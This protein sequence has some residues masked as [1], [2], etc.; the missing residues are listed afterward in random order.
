MAIGDP[1][2]PCFTLSFR[3]N[4]ALVSTVRR[5]VADFYQTWLP[6]ELTSEVALATHELLENAVI[7]SCNGE[8]EV[9]I[10]VAAH[11]TG[12][13]VAIRTRNA[14]SPT[15]LAALREIFEEIRNAPDPDAH[16]Q[17]MM[18]RTAS[19]T[20]G[21]GLGLARIAAETGMTVSLDIDGDQVIISARMEH[22]G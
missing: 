20:E 19:R 11:D 17:A 4:A 16:Y 8:T 22:R 1:A 3:P 18:I 5:F 21:S 15:D 2:L 13:E 14:A 10:E 9:H 6:P 7:H 12:Q